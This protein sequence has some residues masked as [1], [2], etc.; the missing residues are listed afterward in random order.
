MKRH[1]IHS[2]VIIVSYNILQISIIPFPEVEFILECEMLVS[3]H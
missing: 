2:F 3:I 1:E